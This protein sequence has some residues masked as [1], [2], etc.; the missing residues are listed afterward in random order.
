MQSNGGP[1][2][3]GYVSVGISERLYFDQLKQWM[4]CSYSLVRLA[5][6]PAIFT[7]KRDHGK[8][9]RGSDHFK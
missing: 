9:G 7:A 2:Y 5:I 4:T 3:V 6:N 1:L 8:I